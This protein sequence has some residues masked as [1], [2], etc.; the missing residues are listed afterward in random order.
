MTT[1]NKFEGEELISVSSSTKIYIISPNENVM[2][3]GIDN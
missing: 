3:L 2:C 1:A